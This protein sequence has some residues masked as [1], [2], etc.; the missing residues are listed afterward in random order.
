VFHFS[1]V[2]KKKEFSQNFLGILYACS[3]IWANAYFIF[4]VGFLYM[5]LIPLLRVCRESLWQ[6][7]VP[8]GLLVIIVFIRY[9]TDN[10]RAV[11]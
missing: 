1:K 8:P 7:K 2:R 5:S 6:R 10:S 9:V 4:F 11:F 3:G